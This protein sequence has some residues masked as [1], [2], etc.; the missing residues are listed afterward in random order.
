MVSGHA[1]VKCPFCGFE[2]VKA[3]VKP[4]YLG[5]KTSR[6]SAGAKTTLF[7]VPGSCEYMGSCPKCG[8]TSKEMQEATDTGQVKKLTHEERVARLKAAGIPVNLTTT[9]RVEHKDDS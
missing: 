5:G 6:I 2:G 7:R 3:F 4:S 9:T 8:K 1:L